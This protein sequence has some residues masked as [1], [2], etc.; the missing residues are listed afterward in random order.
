MVRTKLIKAGIIGTGGVGDAELEALLRVGGVEVTAICQRNFE[1]L[2]SCAKRYAI[3]KVYTDYRQLIDN[4]EIE[5]VHVITP[6]YLHYEQVTYALEA[7]RHVVCEKPLGV[8]A[9]Q[10]AR[11]VSLAKEKKLVNAVC[12]NHRFFPLVFHARE[13]IERGELGSIT[14]IRGYSLGDFMASISANQP[15]HWRTNPKTVGVSKTMSVYGGHLLDLLQFV[16]GLKIREVFADFGYV[17]LTKKGLTY[18]GQDF[19]EEQG[20]Q[21]EDHANL[22]LRF[23]SG[24]T[25]AVTLSEAALGHKCE[26]FF[27]MI[28]TKSCVAWNLQNVNQLWIGYRE[29]PNNL[30][31]K[32]MNLLYPGGFEIAGPPEW[33]QDGFA[34]SLKHLFSKVY[35]YI[36]EEKYLQNIE[37]DFPTFETGHNM[38]LILQAIM[39]SR[40]NARWER[41]ADRGK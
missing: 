34:D 31:Y 37:P 39:N 12:Y 17:D 20:G 14:L 27:E 22:L 28:G 15:N 10:T 19:I 29:Q 2:T 38:E 26:V 36:R 6:N 16:S 33:A 7:G 23:D 8:N 35:R 30:L 32:D 21:L 41:V 40:K 3:P 13:M 25:G 18:D 11:L 1:R 4:D 9:M 5:V 24:A